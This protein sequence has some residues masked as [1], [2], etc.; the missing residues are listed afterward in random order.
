MALAG[1][2]ELERRVLALLRGYVE[3]ADE[4]EIYADGWEIRNFTIIFDI[5]EPPPDSGA[6]EP[7]DG[8]RTPGWSQYVA[9]TTTIRSDW[10][11]RAAL[12]EA[13]AMLHAQRDEP[14]AE[15]GESR[16]SE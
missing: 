11:R 12:E 3:N 4:N 1:Q 7:Y 8:G 14:S 9:W 15:D 2:E 13:L 6:L 5:H 16:A 10:L